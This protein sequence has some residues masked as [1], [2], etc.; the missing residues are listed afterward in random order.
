MLN[1]VETI[2]SKIKACVKQRMRVPPVKPPCKG[3]ERL[4]FPQRTSCVHGS[5][6]MD[7]FKVFAT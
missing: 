4:T 1:P 6:L 2:W 3:E 7:F 5:M